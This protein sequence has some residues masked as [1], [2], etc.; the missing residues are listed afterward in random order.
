VILKPRF[1]Y[2][3]GTVFADDVKLSG[4]ER[5]PSE[6]TSDSEQGLNRGRFISIVP[7]NNNEQKR[8]VK[9]QI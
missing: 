1:Q 6:L 5:P 4:R 2:F 3:P 7:G 8:Q 9:V